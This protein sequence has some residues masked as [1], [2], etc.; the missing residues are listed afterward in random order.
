MPDETIRKDLDVTAD[1]TVP[2][3]PNDQ[4][5]GESTTFLGGATITKMGSLFFD[6]KTYLA[7]H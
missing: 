1:M 6:D 5:E 7:L 2:E 3:L 4:C